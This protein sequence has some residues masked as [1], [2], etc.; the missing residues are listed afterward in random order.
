VK[1]SIERKNRKV[2]EHERWIQAKRE[3]LATAD[4]KLTR[5]CEAIV[6]AA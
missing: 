4:Q 2:D 5:A 6:G 1:E 3:A